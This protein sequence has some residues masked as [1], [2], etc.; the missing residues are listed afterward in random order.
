M[1]VSH[2]CLTLTDEMRGLGMAKIADVMPPDVAIRS[3][4]HVL[5]S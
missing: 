3:V 4:D 1:P 5:I 2:L